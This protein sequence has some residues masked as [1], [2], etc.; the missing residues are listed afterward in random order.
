MEI[1]SSNFPLSVTLSHFVCIA[2]FVLC[3][4]V[5]VRIRDGAVLIKMAA[6]NQ[7][8]KIEAVHFVS[9]DFM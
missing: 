4:C 3:L 8:L 6:T 7:R 1:K 9:N 2:G 5:P